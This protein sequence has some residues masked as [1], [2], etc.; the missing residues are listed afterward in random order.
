MRRHAVRGLL[1][2]TLLAAV[3]VTVGSGPASATAPPPAP[4]GAPSAARTVAPGDV[5]D[6]GPLTGAPGGP[7]GL[8]ARTV[9]PGLGGG[10]VML[11][12]D[13]AT[14]AVVPSVAPPGTQAPTGW[15]AGSPPGLL[16][17]SS[18]GHTTLRLGAGADGEPSTTS[19][20]P[21][22]AAPGWS[23]VLGS[24]GEGTLRLT[25]LDEDLDELP[26]RAL[27]FAGT[28]APDPA[29][30]ALLPVW[31]PSTGTLAPAPAGAT[32][33]DAS[34]ASAWLRPRADVRAVVATFDPASVND[35]Y[36]AW[37]AA[38]LRPVT[39]R[40]TTLAGDCDPTTAVLALADGPGPSA[41]VLATTVPGPRGAFAFARVSPRPGLSVRLAR[42]PR[43]CRGATS[44]VP[45]TFTSTG[46]VATL[47]V[48]QVRGSL[49]IDVTERRSGKALRGVTL[50][51]SGPASYAARRTSDEQGRIRFAGLVPGRY[52]LRLLPLAG[53]AVVGEDTFPVVVPGSGE[54]VSTRL[55]LAVRGTPGPAGGPAVPL[56]PGAVATTTTG[57]AA[58]PSVA[59]AVTTTTTATSTTGTSTSAT[60]GRGATTTGSG[61][62]LPD[63]G[64]PAGSL[65]WLGGGLLLLGA[66]LLRGSRSPAAPS[67]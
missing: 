23:L 58:A 56:V 25:A 8:V 13:A 6:A 34:G 55:L 45:L 40:L 16:F 20:H 26:V 18:R 22:R 44:S 41:D 48:R 53:Y 17:G 46:A 36:D 11:G 57:A 2:A 10:G 49:S 5:A 47:G 51:L 32:A 62:G 3:P 4:R 33:P 65:P 54:A 39:G 37:V 50:T 31:D 38:P 28:F 60:T 59:G 12:S 30:G 9:L 67:R 15:S 1:A 63:T 35:T 42:A 19:W 14:A 43:G 29:P 27:G 66:A 24:V 21:D 61:S 7:G 52:S 64:G